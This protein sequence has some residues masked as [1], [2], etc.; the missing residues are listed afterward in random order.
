MSGGH[1]D[2]SYLRV[3]QFA[4]ELERDLRGDKD[5]VQGFGPEVLAELELIVNRAR[6]MALV[7]KEVE[8]LFSGDTGSDTFIAEIRAI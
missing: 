5:W 4:D 3:H 7:M 2:Y 6:E 8:W 1:F